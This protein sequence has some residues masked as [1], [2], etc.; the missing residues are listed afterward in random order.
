MPTLDPAASAFEALS[1]PDRYLGRYVTNLAASAAV[2]NIVTQT[3]SVID[4]YM[5]ETETLMDTIKS[6]V[7]VVSKRLPARVNM[8][9][10]PIERGDA[11]GPD[12]LSPVWASK[13]RGDRTLD[14]IARLRVAE[15]SRPRFGML[16]DRVGKR[17]QR[18]GVAERGTLLVPGLLTLSIAE[19]GVQSYLRASRHV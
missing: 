6:R 8:W 13:E 1:D 3:N 5:R 16:D 12:L 19:T 14:E 2:P 15:R 7:P 18:L 10:E 4:P 9:G 17:K 11:L